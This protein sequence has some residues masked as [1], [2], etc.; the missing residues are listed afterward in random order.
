[1]GRNE[2]SFRMTAWINYDT[3]FEKKFHQ[4]MCHIPLLVVNQSRKEE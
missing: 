1:M 4:R 3:A 2:K